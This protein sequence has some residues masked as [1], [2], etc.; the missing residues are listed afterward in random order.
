MYRYLV[1]LACAFLVTACGSTHNGIPVLHKGLNRVEVYEFKKTPIDF[2]RMGFEE[3]KSAT[4]SGELPI[5][6]Y[7]LSERQDQLFPI[8]YLNNKTSG[9]LMVLNMKN[10]GEPQKHY[11]GMESLYNPDF[12]FWLI[13]DVRYMFRSG[14]LSTS[15]DL[16]RMHQSPS[17]LKMSIQDTPEAYEYYYK[18]I[19]DMATDRYYREHNKHFMPGIK[20]NVGRSNFPKVYYDVLYPTDVFSFMRRCFPRSFARLHSVNKNWNYITEGP[21]NIIDGCLKASL[22]WPELNTGMRLSVI[23]PFQVAKITRLSRCL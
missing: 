7:E 23:P 1:G 13:Q 2:K 15:I 14:K 11:Q 9:T 22:K 12:E 21:T 8:N 5:V 16:H 10:V 17:K 3:A 4:Q 19:Q 18:V 20:K 6:Q